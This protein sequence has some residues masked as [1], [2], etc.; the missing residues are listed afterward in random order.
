MNN[1]QYNYVVKQLSN[2]DLTAEEKNSIILLA[3][4]QN[5]QCIAEALGY[6]CHDKED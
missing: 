4:L 1:K 2:K 3:I 6:G 5:L